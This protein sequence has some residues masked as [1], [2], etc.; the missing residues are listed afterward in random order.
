MPGRCWLRPA[1]PFFCR[2]SGHRHQLRR[3]CHRKLGRRMA[4]QPAVI[5]FLMQDHRHCLRVDR[6]DE[7]VG[8]ARQE[9]IARPA[10]FHPPDAGEGE[11]LTA[12]HGEP[13]PRAICQPDGNHSER[14]RGILAAPEIVDRRD[15]YQRQPEISE[16]LRQGI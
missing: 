3:I 1:P 5:I 4:V 11:N 10:F 15:A 12:G 6:P 7:R 2:S 14:D 9:G 13:C 16:P 8:F